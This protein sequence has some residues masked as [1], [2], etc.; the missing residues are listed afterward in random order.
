M[1]TLWI[2]IPLQLRLQHKYNVVFHVS[3]KI[4]LLI[5]EKHMQL[6]L[7]GDLNYNKYCSHFGQAESRLL[8]W[9]KTKGIL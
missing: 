1:A 9:E 7:D 3:Y 8:H 2:M 4:F 6:M 5:R